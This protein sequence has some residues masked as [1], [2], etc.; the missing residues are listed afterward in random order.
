ML[1]SPRGS[2]TSTSSNRHPTSSGPGLGFGGRKRARKLALVMCFAV[3]AHLATGVSSSASAQP[4]ENQS[5]PV[6]SFF[7]DLLAKCIEII[8]PTAQD[9]LSTETPPPPAK[10]DTI[11]NPVIPFPGVTPTITIPGPVITLPREDT[12]PVVTPPETSPEPGPVLVVP[13]PVMGAGLPA[14][15]AWGAFAWFR[16]RKAQQTGRCELP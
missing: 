13:G 14:L 2:S 6:W 15:M 4:A 12:L 16:R 8:M 5:T 3:T 11:P 7:D 9:T 1:L 10:P